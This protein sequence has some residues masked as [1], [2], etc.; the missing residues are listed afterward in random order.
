MSKKKGRSKHGPGTG[1][2]QEFKL[3]VVR[4]TLRGDATH[5][6]VGR[7]FG[8]STAAVTKWLRQFRTG[9]PDALKPAPPPAPPKRTPAAQAKRDAVVAT[10]TEHPEW[11]TRR[12]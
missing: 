3:A 7:A 6:E 12:I 8:V 5:A 11:G 4:E 9:G 1:Y 10:R 2:A